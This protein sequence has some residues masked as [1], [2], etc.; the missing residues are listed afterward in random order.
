MQSKP[1][2]FNHVRAFCFIRGRLDTE[3][4]HILSVIYDILCHPGPYLLFASP[5]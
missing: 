5:N 1:S 4:W 3:G 2:I